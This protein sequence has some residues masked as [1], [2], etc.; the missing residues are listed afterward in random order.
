MN[1][2]TLEERPASVG[3]RKKD[4]FRK[5]YRFA[6]GSVALDELRKSVAAFSAGVSCPEPLGVGFSEDIGMHYCDFRYHAFE[7]LDACDLSSTDWAF[8]QEQ[9]SLIHAARIDGIRGDWQD[10]LER[11]S[12]WVERLPQE[13]RAEMN[14]GMDRL[15]K[16]AVTC[17]SHCDF[18]LA[19]MARDQETG[20]I[21]IFDFQD[22]CVAVPG[23]DWAYFLASIPWEC[24]ARFSPDACTV[25]LIRIASAIK[26]A[27][28]LRK[29]KDLSSRLRIFNHW[30][31]A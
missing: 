13:I 11:N 30:W 6:D 25:E 7:R 12:V 29:G 27:R 9:L 8:L 22:A 24:A 2:E 21:M 20:R 16:M 15:R 5:Y 23:W 3:C 1:D 28:G 4:V 26:L 19:N 10:Y 17:F 14:E 18:S 31:R